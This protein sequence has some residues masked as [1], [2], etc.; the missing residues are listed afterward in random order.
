MRS[1]GPLTAVVLL[2]LLPAAGAAEGPREPS[3]NDADRAHWAFRPPQR[4]A[5]PAVQDPDW[6]H[7]PVDAFILAHLEKAGLRPAP[8]ADRL[9]LLRRVTFDLTGLPPTPAEVDAFL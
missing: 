1:P 6:V 4:A 7:T 8:P 2:G 3:L 9:T 5:P